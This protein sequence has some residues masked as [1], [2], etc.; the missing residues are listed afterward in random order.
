MSDEILIQART[1]YNEAKG[2]IEKLAEL[3]KKKN[4]KFKF[5]IS[6]KQFDYILQ[7]SLIHAAVLDK[8]FDEV[9]IEFIKD[10]TEYGSV[11]AF[12]NFKMKD[13]VEDFPELTWENFPAV[14]KKFSENAR[15]NF[16]NQMYDFLDG[17]A[18]D[19]V[20]WFAPIDAEDKKTDYLAEI[21]KR[22]EQIINILTSRNGKP[23]ELVADE[24]A[25]AGNLK[26]N[27]LLTRWEK[28]VAD[29]S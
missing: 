5:S 3:A 11:V 21:N 15:K 8:N 9:E 24:V 26:R 29:N 28:A 14:I 10:I 19:F 27:L 4:E 20:K 1:Y 12:F 22:F 16:L 6:M 17:L 18:E 7:L 2:I 13:I 25:A 23:A